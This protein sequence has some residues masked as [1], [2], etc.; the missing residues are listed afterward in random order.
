ML[1]QG[2]YGESYVVY[3]LDKN[4]KKQYL[5]DY[6]R[7]RTRFIN[8]DYKILLKDK[9]VFQ[10]LMSQYLDVPKTIGTVKRGVI[11]TPDGK[12][13]ISFPQ[14][15]EILRGYGKLIIKPLLGSGGFNVYLLRISGQDIFINDKPATSAELEARL[16]ASNH[17]LI[18]EVIEQARYSAGIFPDSA[19]TIRLITMLDPVTGEP[20]IPAAVHRFGV[21][22]S[23][24][25]DNWAQGGVC[26]EIDLETGIMSKAVSLCLAKNALEWHSV[27]PETKAPI[28]GVKVTG[29][30]DLRGKMLSVAGNFPY[31]NYIG[32]DLVVTDTGLKVIEGNSFCGINTLQ[33]HRGLLTD[34]KARAFY[35]YHKVI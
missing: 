29:W 26:A 6:A 8:S 10:K 3:G 11:H 14:F 30:E 17:Y 1:L 23:V 2:F 24:P 12:D 19:N 31:L 16:A 9:D 4:D 7:F 18:S 15:M 27:H 13:I 5:T 22:R 33:A 28:E 25:A 34:P 21:T 35:K 20:F 32:W